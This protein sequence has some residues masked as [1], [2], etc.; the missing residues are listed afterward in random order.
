MTAMCNLR[1]AIGAV[2]HPATT[3]ITRSVAFNKTMFVYR[4]V[5]D[6]AAVLDIIE[7]PDYHAA[8]ASLS[9]YSTTQRMRYAA[10]GQ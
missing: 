4:M 2:A 5:T 7:I 3:P 8:I 1:Q 6:V 10:H 9:A